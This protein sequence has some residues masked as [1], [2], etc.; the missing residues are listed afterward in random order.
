MND[1]FYR[2]RGYS[3]LPPVI[4]WM[5][6][7]NVLFFL[8]DMVAEQVFGFNMVNYFGLHYYTSK[9]FM[10]HQFLTYAFLHGSFAH[11][12]SNMFALWMF[13]TMIENFWGSKKFLIYYIVTAVGAAL[14]QYAFNFFDFE[15]IN[16]AIA[17]YSLHP[18]PV[19]FSLVVDKHFEFIYRI[20][21][22]ANQYGMLQ[23]VYRN[24]AANTMLQDQ[25][26]DFL[27]QLS[28]FK[29]SIPT[30]GASG[31]VF[32]ILLA[33]GMMFPNMEIYLYFLFPIKAKY[34]VFFYG[35]L[36]FYAAVQNDPSDNVAH[37]AH[38]GGMLFGIGLI[39]FWNRKKYDHHNF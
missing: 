6:I 26:L 18:N 21:E 11:I 4:K 24:D 28:T 8:A 33:F 15:S 5:L 36:E 27:N 30:V 13:G 34:F 23:N 19:D 39:F 25:S 3:L 2:P 12:F 31:A 38:L 37:L 7:L 14:T 9:L 32:G 16:A 10:P 17:T 22:V 29:A 20:P 35:L 1:N